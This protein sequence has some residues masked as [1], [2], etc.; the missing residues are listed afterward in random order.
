MQKYRVQTKKT[1]ILKESGFYWDEPNDSV[2]RFTI[3]HNQYLPL[4]VNDTF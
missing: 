3:S 1:P 4:R 2:D